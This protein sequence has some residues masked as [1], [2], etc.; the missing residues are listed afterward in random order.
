MKRSVRENVRGWCVMA[1]ILVYFAVFTIIPIF[2]LFF[3]SF[4]NYGQVITN[5][6]FT[7]QWV[8]F[9]NYKDIFVY[10]EYFKS[11]LITFGIALG[12]V[13]C[14]MTFGL[15]VAV[16]LKKIGRLKGFF[17]T[18]W[19]IPA[20]L[21]SAIVSQFFAIL[22]QNDGIMNAILQ[23]LGKNPIYW[24]LSTGWMWF[25]I[26][27]I[28]TWGGTGGTALYFLAGLN[29][30]DNEIY[31]AASI[32]GAKG[33]SKFYYITLPLLKP[34]TGYIL[35]TGFIGAFNIFEPVMLLSQGGPDGSTK[36]ILYRLYDE[37]FINRKYGF[38]CALSV[39]V[40]F[41]IMILTFI[42]IKISD[43]NIYKVEKR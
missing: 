21:S 14:G 26:I 25:W 33:F 8:G 38:T 29:G 16:G 30:I 35:I 39:I 5:G 19:Y 2:I 15:L 41:I 18:I 40:M 42:N 23:A 34:M 11:I 10:A 43:S 20:L 37:A 31:E 28:V 12:V 27:F 13:V 32:D 1:P 9:K 6:K 22:L 17:R 4:S 24:K 3:L 36:V 7:L